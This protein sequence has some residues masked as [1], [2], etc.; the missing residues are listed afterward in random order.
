MEFCNGQ[1]QFKVPFMIYYHLEALLS[2]PPGGVQAPTKDPGWDFTNECLTQ[3][4]MTGL[5]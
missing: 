5:G 3:T 1:N 2:P 4:N